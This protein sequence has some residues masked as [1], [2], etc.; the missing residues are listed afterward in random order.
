M[1]M[2]RLLK[3]IKPILLFL[4]ISNIVKGQE[5]FTKGIF[6]QNND[7]LRY[8]LLYPLNYDTGSK[9]P[10]VVFLH[11]SGVR[12]SDNERQL[13]NVP[14][15]FMNSAFRL[16]YPCFLL[17]PQCAQNDAWVN[18]PKFPLSIKATDTPT[19][20][21]RLTLA[22]IEK[23]ARSAFVDK[24]RI[25]LT[26]YS[27]GGEGTFDLLTRK[28]G[29]FAAAI[30]VCSVSDTAKAFLIKDIP[31]WVFHGS[32]DE[33][34]N[35]QYARLMVDALK[36]VGSSV[37]YTEYPDDGHKIWSKVYEKSELFSWL[38]NQTR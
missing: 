30:P 3:I 17:V 18:F 1:T 8:R 32:K 16:Q 14:G 28:P 34:N 15:I 4:F 36:R 23:L 6:V 9:Y 29:L 20:S 11:G 38:F 22:L 37:Q 24:K 5:I 21:S 25:Y 13:T 27:M 12:G 31:I 33:V 26:G 2:T 10:V 7:T 19:V 35:V